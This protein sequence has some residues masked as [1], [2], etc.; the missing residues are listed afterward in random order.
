M[1]KM[2]RPALE[3]GAGYMRCSLAA[4]RVALATVAA[5]RFA[6]PTFAPG[7]LAAERTTH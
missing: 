4:R 1:E 7:W 6:D 5:D 3:L 2:D